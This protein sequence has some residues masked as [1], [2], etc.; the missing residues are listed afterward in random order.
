MTFQNR[1]ALQIIRFALAILLGLLLVTGL[2]TFGAN[3]YTCHPD[4]TGSENCWFV[5][6]WIAIGAQQ[7]LSIAFRY[8]QYFVP[9]LS[10]AGVM[11]LIGAMLEFRARRSL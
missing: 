2:V 4:M 3:F 10:G 5:A 6:R 7:S 9:L 8:Q 11:V 1:L